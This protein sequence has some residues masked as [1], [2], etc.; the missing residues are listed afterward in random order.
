ME[1]AETGAGRTVSA[2]KDTDMITKMQRRAGREVRTMGGVIIWNGCTN[3]HA[4]QRWLI[5][6]GLFFYVA[7]LT[8]IRDARSSYPGDSWRMGNRAGS[9]R[10]SSHRQIT[11]TRA[12]EA[13]RQSLLY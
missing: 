7:F 6:P 8:S 12:D 5:S 13:M 10:E 9:L 3:A 4:A 2:C 11:R 1:A